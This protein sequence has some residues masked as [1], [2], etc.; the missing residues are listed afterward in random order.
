MLFVPESLSA[1][2]TFRHLGDNR[3]FYFGENS[4]KDTDVANIYQPSFECK[5]P[6]NICL[7]SKIPLFKHPA[8]TQHNTHFHTSILRFC[9]QAFSL[10][11]TQRHLQPTL[12]AVC[13]VRFRN[14]PLQTLSSSHGKQHHAIISQSTSRS[15]SRLTSATMM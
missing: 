7:T 8:Q 9:A 11:H 14:A 2:Q 4:G 5:P 6:C 1:V 15:V 10:S 12:I 3:Q 13:D